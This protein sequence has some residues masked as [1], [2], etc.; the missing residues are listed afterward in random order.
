MDKINFNYS[1]KN[2]PYGTQGAYKRQLIEKTE[3][4]IKNIRWKAFFF[5][6]PNTKVSDK[7]TFG[8]KSRKTPPVIDELKVF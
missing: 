4:F 8:F 7:E 3:V 1:T 6:N 5:L 2:I